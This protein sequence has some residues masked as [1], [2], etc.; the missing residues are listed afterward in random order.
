MRVTLMRECGRLGAMQ[1][2]ISRAGASCTCRARNFYSLFSFNQNPSWTRR[3]LARCWRSPFLPCRPPPP[4]AAAAAC[5]TAFFRSPRCAGRD[6]NR[7]GEM[8]T[9][10][11]RTHR[12]YRRARCREI[13][14]K[15]MKWIKIRCTE[16]AVETKCYGLSGKKK[17]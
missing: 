4:V 8:R 10:I 17:N 2:R 12:G 3:A 15:N 16:R 5:P 7:V 9:R 11:P 14:E 13:I 1:L 6:S